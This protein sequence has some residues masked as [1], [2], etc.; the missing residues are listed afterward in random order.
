MEILLSSSLT[1]DI[2]VKAF[3][4][5]FYCS[6]QSELKLGF[7]LPNSRPAYL[8]NF[9]VIS[10]SSLPLLLVDLDSLFLPESQQ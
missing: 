6:G 10:P 9:L 3:L 5:L 7:C 2:F 8:S 1:V 4:I